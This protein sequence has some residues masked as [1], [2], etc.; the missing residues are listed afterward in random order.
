MKKLKKVLLPLVALVCAMVMVFGVACNAGGGNN[1]TKTLES[2]SVNSDNAKTQYLLTEDFSS[3]GLEVTAHYSKSDGG[4]EDKNV[5][6]DAEIDSSAFNKNAE[7]TYIITVSY[8]DNGVTKTTTY[9]VTVS[10]P[11]SGVDVILADGVVSGMTLSAEKSERFSGAIEIT[12]TAKT[13]DID[14]TKV[15]VRRPDSFGNVDYTSNPLAATEYDVKVY[16][17]NAEIETLTGLGEGVYQI[18][19]TLKTGG[20]EN[21]ALI[22]VNNSLKTLTFNSEAPG[23]KTEQTASSTS[24]ELKSTWKFTATYSDG[25]T[26]EVTA[27]TAGVK[28]D[29]YDHTK[30]TPEGGSDATVTLTE[31]NAQGI[32]K[33][34]D[35]KVHYVINPKPVVGGTQTY[36]IDFNDTSAIN[37]N[38]S[39]ISGDASADVQI[40][41]TDFF[42]TKSSDGKT[43][44]IETK[45]S[46]PNKRQR[47][48]TQG[49]GSLTKN[50]IYVSVAA[51]DVSVT[52]SY[53][54]SNDGR[55]AK[56]LNDN[57]DTTPE[58]TNLTTTDGKTVSRTVTFTLSEETKIYI[59][60][61]DK[62][63]WI[64][65]I[66][67]TSVPQSA[68][69]S[70]YTFD[71][72]ELKAAITTR[73]QGY[74]ELYNPNAKQTNTPWIQEG[75]LTDKI[76]LFASDFATEKNEFLTPLWTDPTTDG[77]K[78]YK[79]SNIYT[80]SSNECIEIKGE[81]FSI[82]PSKT[83]ILTITFNSTSG[84]NA[85]DLGIKKP[86]GSYLTATSFGTAT[87][88]DSGSYKVTGTGGVTLTF[89]LEANVQY[90]I[91]TAIF[92][93]SAAADTA[94]PSIR[95]AR[96]TAIN[97]VMD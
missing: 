54:N 12:S 33:F 21:F 76:A 89:T 80:T 1:V 18:W 95:A 97:M 79:S 11:K 24:D 17:G 47:L 50:S 6:A 70:S 52:I 23:T 62:G 65:K 49:A 26:K 45:G 91:C 90:K 34:A 16:K 71:M 87:L 56:V 46:D 8:T 41:S 85:S 32:E 55:Y 94:N 69:P 2:I 13:V 7:N 25:T 29:G 67:I 74:S 15:E 60:S 68:T 4:T 22:F 77:D 83:A 48:V 92:N 53:S 57:L 42:V 66:E 43:N 75:A 78:A 28:I 19:V 20:H 51:G 73:V 84:S 5:T 36:S 39:L 44:T 10:R 93:D 27:A 86:D 64:D 37:E 9:S 30:A 31:A 82:Q 58:T 38:K 35:C 88:T 3:D 72:T 61:A 81:G 59:G 96:I 40:Q 14:K 63:I